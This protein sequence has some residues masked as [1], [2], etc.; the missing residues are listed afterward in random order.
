M[1]L[2]DLAAI[3]PYYI[4]IIFDATMDEPMICADSAEG[5]YKKY[6]RQS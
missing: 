1:N 4:T 2:V 5:I 6:I 3:V